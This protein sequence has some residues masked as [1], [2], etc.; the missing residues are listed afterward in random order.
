LSSVFVERGFLREQGAGA[1]VALFG[2]SA[3]E[4]AENVSKKGRRSRLSRAASLPADHRDGSGPPALKNET[5]HE[6][7]N[8]EIKTE[9]KQML[10]RLRLSGILFT[11]MER[12][13]YARGQ[14][15]SYEDFLELVLSD[16]IERRDQGGLPPF[17]AP[18]P[19]L[20][21]FL[22]ICC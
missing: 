12:V 8:M 13:S 1:G 17:I 3:T 20:A 16:E 6:G 19:E 7:G 4:M 22:N 5:N 21:F 9:L 10:K 15:L 18:L 14:K 11:L 2:A